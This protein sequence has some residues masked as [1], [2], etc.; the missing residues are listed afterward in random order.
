MSSLPDPTSP[1][2]ASFSFNL[3]HKT[4][5]IF[6]QMIKYKW[7]FGLANVGSHEDFTVVFVGG[8]EFSLKGH[9]DYREVGRRDL[10]SMHESSHYSLLL[11]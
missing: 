1:I 11:F 6:D 8:G 3:E 2:K 4:K 7:Q 10:K 5:N 9:E